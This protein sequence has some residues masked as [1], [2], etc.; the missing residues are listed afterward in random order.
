M[1][2]N[3]QFIVFAFCL[4]IVSFGLSISWGVEIKKSIIGKWERYDE[5]LCGIESIEFFE[6]GTV[7]SYCANW[8]LSAGGD[9]RFIDENRIK[10]EWGGIWGIVVGPIIYKISVSKNELILTTSDGKIEKYR[11]GS[12]PSKSRYKESNKKFFLTEKRKS[13]YIKP[14][15]PTQK[16]KK[17]SYFL[18]TLRGAVVSC[19]REKCNNYEEEAAKELIGDLLT[20]KSGKWLWWFLAKTEIKKIVAGQIVAGVVADILGDAGLSELLP[21]VYSIAEEEAKKTYNKIKKKLE[22]D[23]EEIKVITLELDW[24]DIWV[25]VGYCPYKRRGGIY[26]RAAG[27]AIVVFYSPHSMTIKEIRNKIVSKSAWDVIY[28]PPI[29]RGVSIIS[30]NDE[31]ILNQK[32]RPFILVIRGTIYEMGDII[33]YEMWGKTIAGPTVIFLE[34]VPT[35]EEVKKGNFDILKILFKKSHFKKETNTDWSFLSSNR[36]FFVS[37]KEDNRKLSLW[38]VNPDGSN[39]VEILPDILPKDESLIYSTI[40]ADG[41]KLAYPQNRIV[42]LGPYGVKI[43]PTKIIIVDFR[44]IRKKVLTL[45][46]HIVEIRYLRW[47]PDATK[48]VFQSC[49]H[50]LK[51][52]IY[53]IDVARANLICLTKNLRVNEGTHPIWLPDGKKV[54]FQNY[55]DSEGWKFY[56]INADGSGKPQLVHGIGTIPEWAPYGDMVAFNCGRSLCVGRFK[57]FRIKEIRKLTQKNALYIRWSFD[58]TKIIFTTPDF[59][60]YIINADGGNLKRL[61]RLTGVTVFLIGWASNHS[62]NFD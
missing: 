1:K 11:K 44:R 34:R 16:F 55:K 33:K 8:K 23:K 26:R 13:V 20:R 4:M 60:T 52:N 14:C 3:K 51:Y 2:S 24:K 17:I 61:E 53:V 46:S 40:S 6:D 41:T 15:L 25:A 57:D 10:I 58:G 29:K 39:L 7:Y 36:I 27:E 18:G 38:T 21:Y 28:V 48:I 50:N 62:Q 54:M 47:S 32:V 19:P 12:L 35:L 59:R 22:K 31:R 43:E 49:S 37:P 30:L 9:Y 42:S 5:K 45:P 56:L